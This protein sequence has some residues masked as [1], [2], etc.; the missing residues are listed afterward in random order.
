MN[1]QIERS[2]VLP[3][4]LVEKIA[5]LI[6]QQPYGVVAPIATE[7]G[8]LVTEQNKAFDTQ[9]DGETPPGDGKPN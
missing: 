9:A 4:S 6:N 1:K 2:Y 3:A 7:L 5:N 8:I